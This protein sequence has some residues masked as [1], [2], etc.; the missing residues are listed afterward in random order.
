MLQAMNTGHEG[1]ITTVHANSPDDALRRIEAMVVM[2]GLEL[3]AKI[4]R[5]YIVGALEIIVQVNRL[6]D[7]TRKIVSISELK[8]EKDGSF[9]IQEIFKFK[10]TGMTKNGQ[11]LGH[12][13]ATG[14]IPQCLE[15]I[16]VFGNDIPESV[17]M[18]PRE[19]RA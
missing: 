2:A 1:S 10:R 19:V 9:S 5:E 11:V 15:R 7:G 16:K 8:K 18:Q 14:Y 4:I 17:F 3:P 13:T 12:Y 6:T